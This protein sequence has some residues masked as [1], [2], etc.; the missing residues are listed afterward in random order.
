[1]EDLTITEAKKKVSEGEFD[2]IY[3]ISQLQENPDWDRHLAN[4]LDGCEIVGRVLSNRNGGKTI[5]YFIER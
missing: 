5:A 2:A 1:M 4:I 3:G